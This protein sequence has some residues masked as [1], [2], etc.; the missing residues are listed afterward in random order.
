MT[1][2]PQNT[3]EMYE[4][5]ER[6]YHTKQLKRTI[7]RRGTGIGFAVIGTTLCSL[8]LSLMFSALLRKAGMYDYFAAPDFGNLDPTVYYVQYGLLY[9][10]A[11]VIPF[12]ILAL[13]FR[14]PLR[15]IFY[16]EERLD[17]RVPPILL[18]GFGIAMAA[19]LLVSYLV[20]ALNIFGVDVDLTPMPFSSEPVDILLYGVI[21]AV[22]PA[23]AEEFCYRGVVMGLLRPF[24]DGFAVIAS[25][26]IF[27]AMHGNAVQI[28]FAFSVGLV[29]GFVTVKTGSMWP[30]ML[31]HFLNN[32]ISFVQEVVQEC[33]NETV[34]GVFSY[35]SMLLAAVCGL[36][37]MAW[38]LKKDPEFFVLQRRKS[39]L[40][41]KEKFGW[42]ICNIGMLG[43][44]GYLA[45]EVVLQLKLL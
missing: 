20:R 45:V 8:V 40:S 31:L 6:R 36:I 12:A 15:E 24:G 41:E 13:C 4:E 9:L 44:L 35:G 23:F 43:C 18:A 29:L 5:Q 33:A 10:S 22:L 17:R 3:R 14:L 42:F 1:D 27:G 39:L 28:P 25:A 38:L 19:N 7:R 32:G 26:S 30:A 16:F 21:L 2:H 11:M 34:S 37:G